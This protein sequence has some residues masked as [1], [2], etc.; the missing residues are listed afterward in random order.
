LQSLGPNVSRNFPT[1]TFVLSHAKAKNPWEESERLEVENYV[2]APML[3]R[4]E[5]EFTSIFELQSTI[6][7]ALSVAGV[8]ISAWAIACAALGRSPFNLGA[9]IGIFFAMHV[10]TIICIGSALGLYTKRFGNHYLQTRFFA[11]FERL[12][13]IS[14]VL[15]FFWT[16]ICI[17]LMMSSP[18]SPNVILIFFPVCWLGGF[19]TSVL[20]CSQLRSN[21]ARAS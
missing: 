20:L 21:S 1:S 13:W 18:S 7:L 15:G 19:I 8:A 17:P 11:R 3:A 9:H 2:L 10:L 14:G 4:R 16:L 5:A 12:Y 6:V